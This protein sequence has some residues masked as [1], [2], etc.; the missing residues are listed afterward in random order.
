MKAEGCGIRYD[1]AR[2]HPTGED[3]RKLERSLRDAQAQETHAVRCPI[4]G[5]L[6]AYVLGEKKGIVRVK[7]GKCGHDGP[8]N[9]AYF[10][11]MDPGRHHRRMQGH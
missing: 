5:F 10:R 3:L 2:Y 6:K 7:C 9:L 1:R 11:R 8:M 4:C